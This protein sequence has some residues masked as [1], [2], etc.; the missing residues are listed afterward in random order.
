M[1]AKKALSQT[2]ARE[3]SNEQP[4]TLDRKVDTAIE[5]LQLMVA[6]EL[7]K[8][9]VTQEAIGKHLHVAKAKVGNMLKGVKREP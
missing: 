6:I 1:K 5:L 7:W 3:R 8:S 2:T 4:A 9:G